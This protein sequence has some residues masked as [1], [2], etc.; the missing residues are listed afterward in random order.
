[1]DAQS[2]LV[3]LKLTAFNTLEQRYGE[4]AAGDYLNIAAQALVQ[5][6]QSQDRLFH[7]DRDVLMAV[8]KRHT[9][10]AAMSTELSRLTTSNRQHV[11]TVNGRT[12]M[13]A[14]P[15]TFDLLP[16]LQFLSIDDILL[17]FNANL[18]GKV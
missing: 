6:L 14:S 1:M 4:A 11:M 12:V 9:S 13:I 17:V 8:M 15:I 10:P 16:V 7:W 2:Y 5:A 3:L 18:S